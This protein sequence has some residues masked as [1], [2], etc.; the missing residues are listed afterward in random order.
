MTEVSDFYIDYDGL[1]YCKKHR[2]LV[3]YSPDGD[4]CLD[5]KKELE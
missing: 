4:Y 5:C 3:F 2:T 1:K